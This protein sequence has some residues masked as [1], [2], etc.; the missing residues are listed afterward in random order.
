LLG[1]YSPLSEDV[2]CSSGQFSLV[3]LF[4]F[5]RKTLEEIF[6]MFDLDGNNLLSREEFSWFNIRTSDEAVADDEWRV[7]EG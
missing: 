1:P 6:D 5:C 7:V 4:T 2:N 3:Y